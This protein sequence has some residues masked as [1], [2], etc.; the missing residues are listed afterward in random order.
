MAITRLGVVFNIVLDLSAFGVAKADDS[1]SLA[2]INKGHVVQTVDLWDQAD[3]AEL[4]VFAAFINP[5]ES[6]VPGELPSERQRQ[7]VVGK[8]ELVF[9]RVEVDAHALV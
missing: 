8:V 3:H 1:T 6:F 9:G 7:T 4:V 5:Y 2:A